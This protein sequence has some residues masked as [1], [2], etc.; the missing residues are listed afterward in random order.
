MSGYFYPLPPTQI[1]GRQPYAPRLGRIESG[2]TPES[3]PVRSFAA[4]G[5]LLASWAP[6]VLAL[7]QAARI[8]PLI[9]ASS[10]PDNPPPVRRLTSIIDAQW[11][12]LPITVIYV[13]SIAPTLTTPV[14][15]DNAPVRSDAQLNCLLG[16][17][18]T[19]IDD[20]FR[21]LPD[22]TRIAPLLPA[23]V[24]PDDPPV[25]TYTNFSVL[26]QQ[27]IPPYIPI[28]KLRISEIATE[29]APVFTG[30]IPNQSAA[31]NSGT[32]QYDLS[33]YFSGATSYSID[34]AVEAGWSFDTNTGILEID[35]DA[36]GAFGAYTVTAT[37]IRGNTDSNAFTISVL[38][39]SDAISDLRRRRI[40]RNTRKILQ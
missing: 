4:L 17:W 2:P 23:A 20:R 6:A 40:F 29:Q 30:Q 9:P 24:L 33:T 22:Q 5:I 21:F 8:A 1:G 10:P 14:A 28:P 19:I 26:L 36:E 12:Q 37:N 16:T 3:A 13:S 34:P 35:T 15:P 32:Y 25:S 38:Q 31:F 27:W 7:P 39:S 11:D 18:Q